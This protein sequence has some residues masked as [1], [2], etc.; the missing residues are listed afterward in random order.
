MFKV[1]L[2]KVLRGALRL[3]TGERS[4]AEFDATLSCVA[5][6]TTTSGCA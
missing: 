6:A 2:L 3:N 1:L 5:G 4:G